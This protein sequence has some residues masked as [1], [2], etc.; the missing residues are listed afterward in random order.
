MRLL[1]II[2]ILFGASCMADTVNLDTTET[3]DSPVAT[4]MDWT[5]AL[6][7]AKKKVL[8]VRWRWLDATGNPIR[9]ADSSRSFHVWQC[10]NIDDIHPF[11][12][13]SE[14]VGAGDPYACCTGAG[15]G[16]CDDSD[17]CFSQV[18]SF[19][20]REQDVGVSMGVGLRKLIW[21]KM[22]QDILSTGNNGTFE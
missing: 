5:V 7:D 11:K 2:F 18:F 9:D 3:I 8:S 21:N 4:S 16:S 1:P 13:N 19:S 22:R 12:S 15:A 10:R 20:I 6:I 17:N 14:C